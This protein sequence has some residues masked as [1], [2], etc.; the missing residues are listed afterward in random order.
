V[1]GADSHQVIS[2]PVERIYALGA[3]NDEVAVRNFLEQF[4]LPNQS[5][6]LKKWWTLIW[7]RHNSQMQNTRRW[8]LRGDLYLTR[9]V[10]SATHGHAMGRTGAIS[11]VKLGRRLGQLNL[12]AIEL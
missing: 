6:C 7:R 10:Y 5:E 3:E 2:T 12:Q 11:S 1:L 4:L 9:F 8:F